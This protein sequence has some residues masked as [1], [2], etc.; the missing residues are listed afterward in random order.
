MFLSGLSTHCGSALVRRTA[1]ISRTMSTVN[2]IRKL[3]RNPSTELGNLASLLI[4]SSNSAANLFL[5]ESTN[6]HQ[7][8]RLVASYSLTVLLSNEYSQAKKNSRRRLGIR[9]VL[10]DERGVVG[11][12]AGVS[13]DIR[14]E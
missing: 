3:C 12:V 4:D 11:V 8:A 6:S 7:R 10:S 13:E 1:L 9:V 14:E 5:Q 2:N